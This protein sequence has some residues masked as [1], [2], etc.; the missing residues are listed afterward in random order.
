MTTLL[1][2]AREMLTTDE[3]I[4]FLCSMLIKYIYISFRRKARTVNLNEQKALLLW[5]WRKQKTNI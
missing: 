5:S 1:N 4:L 2:Q 3:K